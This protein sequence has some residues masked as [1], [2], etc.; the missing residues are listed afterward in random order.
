MPEARRLWMAT[1]SL[2]FGDASPLPFCLTTAALLDKFDH[3]SFGKQAGQ[4]TLELALRSNLLQGAGEN[5]VGLE[6]RRLIQRGRIRRAKAADAALRVE[7]QSVTRKGKDRMSFRVAE[8][9]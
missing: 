2:G 6:T 4:L 8:F 1:G 7:R 3:R 9:D 5:P